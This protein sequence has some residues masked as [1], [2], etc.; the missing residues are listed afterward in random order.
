M[1]CR[2]EISAS[3]ILE[4]D[5]NIFHT[6]L[7]EVFYS[8][9]KFLVCLFGKAR[10]AHIS[11]CSIGHKRSINTINGN[12]IT[13]YTEC[14]QILLPFTQ[15]FEHH[16]CPL[17]ATQQ[18]YDI[19]IFL[20]YSR[21]NSIV[22]TNNTVAWNDA[23]LF[24]WSIGKSLQH[25]KSVGLHIECNANTAKVTFER[26]GHLFGLLCIRICRVWIESLEH[27]DDC[28]L[29]NLVGIYCINIIVRYNPLSITQFLRRGHLHTLSKR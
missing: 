28:F 29:Y 8:L 3:I 17:R 21:N 6:L 9:Q 23:H 18:L 2:T 5:N 10:Y 13:H 25:I 12:I 19:V 11:S 4:V 16:L 27:R 1:I 24:R 20:F 14:Q 22:C 26:F 7:F 15:Y